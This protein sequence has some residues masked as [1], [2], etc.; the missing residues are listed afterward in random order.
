MSIIR[1][2]KSKTFFIHLG[3]AIAFGIAF[4][5]FSLKMLDLYTMH[6]KTIEVPDLDGLDQQVAIE[7]L[8]DHNLNAVINDSIFD[9]DREKGTVSSQNPPAGEAV[10]KNRT[11]YLTTVAIL[12][13]MVEMPDLA[14]LSLRQALAIIDNYGLEVGKLEYI[15]NIARDNVLQQKYNNG[16]IQP[17]TLI[18]KG[19]AIDLVLGTGM[20]GNTVVVPF[21]VGMPKKEANFTINRL[22]LNIGEEVYL[23][24][25][26]SPDLRV[27]SQEPGM[28]SSLTRLELGSEIDLVYRS[29]EN[30][31]F[32][33]YMEENL[34][35]PNPVLSGLSPVEV[36]ETLR[37]VSLVLGE[38]LYDG[39]VS[40]ARA[41]AYKQQPD[42]EEE[43]T[44]IKGT[45]IN[46]WYM[47]QDEYED[48]M[49]Q[50]DTE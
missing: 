6:N 50:Q 21:L 18:E 45:T 37:N 11:V 43:P 4:L 32:Q 7:V 9:S 42:P 23:D 10:K 34:S 46:V 22:S 17:G 1:F 33:T 15:P 27:Y 35:I 44:V 47:D 24:P 31:D 5:W 30:F 40:D 12:P 13:E 49:E 20:Q 19:T 25:E 36:F 29:G 14:D 2:L 39:N 16:T 3:L 48:M 26:D 28:E 41:V 38:E 8:E